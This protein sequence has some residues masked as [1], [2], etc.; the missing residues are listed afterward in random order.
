MWI[1]CT[2]AKPGEKLA[3][4]LKCWQ[5]IPPGCIQRAF[6]KPLLPLTH[7]R[8]G[9]KGGRCVCEIVVGTQRGW[10]GSGR[11]GGQG[12]SGW[13]EAAPPPPQVSRHTAIH[14]INEQ[15]HRSTDG[16]PGHPAERPRP[17]RETER[18]RDASWMRALLTPMS[19]LDCSGST[20][21]LS[22]ERGW[23]GASESDSTRLALG[24]GCSQT[25]GD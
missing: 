11:P 6:C 19:Q 24:P 3:E 10:G 23:Q 22:L 7:F 18:P 13:A 14:S 20:P 2:P 15:V 17:G 21:L 1:I 9:R 25:T 4:P 5:R 12:D 8:E 16:H